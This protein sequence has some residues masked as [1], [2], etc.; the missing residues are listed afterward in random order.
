MA[1]RSIGELNVKITGSAQQ[2]VQ[3]MNKADAA[4]KGTVTKIDRE[5]GQLQ[6]S[7]ARKFSLSDV[8]KDIMRGFGIGSGFAVAQ[9]AADMM[10]GYWQ[11]AAEAAKSIE[12]STARQLANVQALLRMRQ[13][14]GR[15]IEVIDSNLAQLEAKR[16]SLMAG[17]EEKRLVGGQMNSRWET[18]RVGP[19]QEAL[20]EAQ[21]ISEEMS[22]LALD[23][24]VLAKKVSD[25]ALKSAEAGY[26]LVER[27]DKENADAQRRVAEG[28]AKDKQA[29]TR[30]QIEYEQDL[31]QSELEANEKRDKRIAEDTKQ[32]M[33]DLNAAIF[34]DAE[35]ALEGIRPA[36]KAFESEM[37]MMWNSVSDRAGQMFADMVMTGKASF[38]QLGDLI[39]RS[40]VE[41]V[42]RMAIINPLLNM[43]FGGFGGWSALPAFFGAGAAPGGGG[44]AIGG[45]VNAGVAYTVGERGR[46]MFIPDTAGTII[47]A[48]QTSAMLGGGG[49]TYI[50]DARGADQGAVARIERT[51]MMLA[52]PGVVERR[53]VSAVTDRS[54]RMAT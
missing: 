22:K 26:A 18:V 45:P 31:Y 44:K 30:E 2:L 21:R 51:L 42:A 27:I 47:P 7:L 10:V 28:L 16:L 6:R 43:L 52:G 35:R 46:E 11:K 33:A 24:A 54:F 19:S 25:D 48:E 8:S 39:S 38:A 49:N 1:G 9:Q 20:A 3:E 37:A 12:E 15:Q 13:T 23:R 53:A 14:D 4:V 5:M 34:D 17:T 41:I 40:V 32:R 29:I 50:I 36:M